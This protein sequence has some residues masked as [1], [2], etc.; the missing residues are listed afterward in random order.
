MPSIETSRSAIQRATSR[1]E[2]FPADR[3]AQVLGSISNTSFGSD[4]SR[5]WRSDAGHSNRTQSH[6]G[7]GGTEVRPNWS[8]EVSAPVARRQPPPPDSEPGPRPGSRAGRRPTTSHASIEETAFRLFREHRFEATTVQTIDSQCGIGR[9]TLFR[10]FECMTC[11]ARRCPNCARTCRIDLFSE[12]DPPGH[13]RAYA[14][15]AG[16]RLWFRTSKN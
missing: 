1:S 3:R 13:S 5:R 11:L 7:R 8:W 14:R 6:I 16:G 15:C 10:Y 4:G 12:W 9:R 2:Q